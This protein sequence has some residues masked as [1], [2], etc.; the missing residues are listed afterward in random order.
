MRQIFFRT[1][2]APH[3]KAPPILHLSPAP[4]TP[5][6]YWVVVRRLQ[7][8]L[9]SPLPRTPVNPI[10][11]LPEAALVAPLQGTCTQGILRP[12]HIAL[13]STQSLLP[14][15]PLTTEMWRPTPLLLVRMLGFS[16]LGVYC[17]VPFFT[18]ATKQNFAGIQCTHWWARCEDANTNPSAL[19]NRPT[20]ITAS[21]GRLGK[22]GAFP[23]KEV[24]TM[25][26]GMQQQAMG[27]LT[28]RREWGECEHRKN[29]YTQWHDFTPFNNS[30]YASR[31]WPVPYNNKT[32]KIRNLITCQGVPLE[33]IF[34]GP[35]LGGCCC[36]VCSPISN[37]S[38]FVIC[39]DM[40][41]ALITLS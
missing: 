2:V 11:L 28:L 22:S 31:N 34:T 10:S 7:R 26:E 9:Q 6:M 29:S 14:D 19:G 35:K 17:V 21:T 8:Q 18:C 1:T 25:K 37:I 36:P 12:C 33:K 15:R 20:I 39:L 3:K 5:M 23:L 41:I 4:M 27:W 32:P 40:I 16:S 30:L 24:S 38:N 13:F